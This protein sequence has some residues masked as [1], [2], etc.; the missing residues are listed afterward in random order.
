ML[1]GQACPQLTNMAAMSDMVAHL[2]AAKTA[3]MLWVSPQLTKLLLARLL[4]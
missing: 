3:L 1:M 2:A 4:M